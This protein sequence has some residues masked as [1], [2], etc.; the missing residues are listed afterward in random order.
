VEV[1]KRL[2][3]TRPA[4]LRGNPRARPLFAVETPCD[5]A[6]FALGMF[7][8]VAAMPNWEARALRRPFGQ[9]VVARSARV[10][11]RGIREPGLA[12]DDRCWDRPAFR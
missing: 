11:R 4:G 5:D 3:P 8:G 9:L 12:F 1:E 7:V 6:L 10:V 2:D